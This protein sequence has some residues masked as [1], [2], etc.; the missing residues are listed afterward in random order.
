MGNFPRNTIDFPQSLSD[1]KCSYL[2]FLTPTVAVEVPR[3]SLRGDIGTKLA[4][5]DSAHVDFSC[6][7]FAIITS[8]VSV[9]Q[10]VSPSA[11]SGASAHQYNCL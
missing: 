9:L 6:V 2:L 8:S 1:E 5:S 7:V 10:C 3:K 4:A 11:F